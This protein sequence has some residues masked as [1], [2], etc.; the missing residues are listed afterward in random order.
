MDNELCYTK[1]NKKMYSV[2]NIVDKQRYTFIPCKT[3]NK[4]K[5]NKIKNEVNKSIEK[6]NISKEIHI[7]ENDIIINDWLNEDDTIQTVLNKIG[8]YCSNTIGEHIYA[9]YEKDKPL[10]FKYNF[11]IDVPDKQ[12]KPDNRFYS[13][14]LFNNSVNIQNNFNILMENIET[15]IIGKYVNNLLSFEEDDSE[16][17]LGLLKAIRHIQYGES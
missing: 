16:I 12:T 10:G 17:N 7:H 11:D 13:G 6:Y 14:E 5:Y 1:L 4:K 15:D 2:I 3:N 8:Y 9:F